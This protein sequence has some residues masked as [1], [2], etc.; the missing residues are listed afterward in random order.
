MVK[1]RLLAGLLTS[2]LLLGCINPAEMVTAAETGD[3]T[4]IACQL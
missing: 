2:V 3:V 4:D 1:R